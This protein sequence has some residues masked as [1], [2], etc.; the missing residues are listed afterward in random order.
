[1]RMI[2]KYSTIAG[3][4]FLFLV[5]GCDRQ[6]EESEN[7]VATNVRVPVRISHIFKGNIESTVTATGMTDAIR[8]EK[9]FSPIAGRVISLRVLEGSPV[10]AGDVMLILR[11]KEAQATIEGAQALLRSATTERQKE[12]AQRAQEL[13][14]SLQPE[15]LVKASFDGIVA[16]RSITQGEFV[17]DQAELLTLIDVSTIVF[18]ADVPI[19]SISSIHPGLPARVRFPQL[20]I[21]QVSAVVDAISPEADL[22]SQS[23]KVRLRYRSLTGT[24]QRLLIANVP[25]TAEIIT[26]S[27]RNVLL[28]DRST[29]LHDDE[30]DT[31]SIVTMTQD[32]VARVIPVTAG[33]QTDSLVEVHSDLLHP[34]ETVIV[35]GQYA[36][37]DSTRVRVE[38]Q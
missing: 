17:A 2:S 1:M 22:Q 24:Q 18:M 36:L 7:S 9:V 30:T 33:L 32:S 28:T 16:S 37:T 6:K 12:E 14:D 34:G 21:G 13:A 5:V 20:S 19:S 10:H 25:G 15:I 8:K 23:V 38:S 26:G 11:T 3:V 29:L 35:R 27:H 31:Y 4:F